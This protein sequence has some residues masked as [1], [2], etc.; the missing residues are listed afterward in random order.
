MKNSNIHHFFKWSLQEN[1][2]IPTAFFKIWNSFTYGR[3]KSVTKNWVLLFLLNFNLIILNNFTCV[4]KENTVSLFTLLFSL[5]RHALSLTLDRSI[6]HIHLQASH[7]RSISHVHLLNLSLWIL[8][9]QF[10]KSLE[11]MLNR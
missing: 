4:K 8:H 1:C 10:S 3:L 7:P 11:S 2:P 9:P 6:S 5:T